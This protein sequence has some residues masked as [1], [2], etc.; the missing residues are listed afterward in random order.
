MMALDPVLDRYLRTNRDFSTP[1][2]AAAVAA[3]DLR[4]GARVLDLGTGAGGALAP[5]AAAVGSAGSVLG[6]DLNPAVAAL[7]ADHAPAGVQVRVGDGLQVLAAAPVDLVW[8]C[9]VVWPGN[10]EDPAA[11]TTSLLEGVR[12]GGTVA[13]LYSGYYY[14]RFLPGHARLE[15]LVRLASF[16]R[17]ALPADGPHQHDN[18][19]AWMLGAGATDTTVQI[20]P[21]I[22]FPTEPA[23][24]AYLESSV[25]PEMATSADQHGTEV[26]LTAEDLVDLRALTTPGNPC[27]APDQPGYHVVQTAALITG[28]RP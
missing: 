2:V 12:P 19:L 4:P 22:G 27:Y 20:L 1:V 18:A 13:L 17:W 10:F 11:A 9:D 5:L 26:G 3:L 28:R 6:V 16:R 24:M 8:A 21:R 14:A 25:W 7:A 15:L 23:T